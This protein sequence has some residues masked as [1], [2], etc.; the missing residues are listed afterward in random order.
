MLRK[1]SEKI[2]IHQSELCTF[3]LFLFS[4]VYLDINFTYILLQYLPLP[5]ILYIVCI[6]ILYVDIHI[7]FC[8]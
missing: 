8:S 2:Y 1:R 6:H 7:Q 3:Y 5:D 4:K